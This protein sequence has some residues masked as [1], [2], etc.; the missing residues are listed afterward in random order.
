VEQGTNT[1][2]IHITTQEDANP[3]EEKTYKDVGVQTMETPSVL[4]NK[5]SSINNAT[6]VHEENKT[7]K[8]N[9]ENATNMIREN[10]ATRTP[11]RHPNHKSRYLN[12]LEYQYHLG[13]KQLTYRSK[14]IDTNAQLSLMI[15]FISGSATFRKRLN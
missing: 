7:P 6:S 1:D 13:W 4:T 10:H 15:T 9:Q 3:V 12:Q 5:S 14:N 11:Y 2:P 8:E